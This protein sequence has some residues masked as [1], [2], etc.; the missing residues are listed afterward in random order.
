MIEEG[1]AR[2]GELNAMNATRQQGYADL[3]FEIADLPAQRWLRRVQP[4]LGGDRQTAL[5]GN[6]YEISDVAQLHRLTPCLQGM[7]LNQQSLFARI[8][9]RLS[10]MPSAWHSAIASIRSSIMTSLSG[11][12]ALVTG[13]SRGIGRAS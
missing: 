5:L 2:G 6:R 13:A 1:L 12:T 11:K 8:N 9:G 4:A 7:E 10:H 3:I